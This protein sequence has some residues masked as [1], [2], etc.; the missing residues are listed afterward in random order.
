MKKITLLIAFI[1]TAVMVNAQ[2]INFEK[3]TF[4]DAVSKAKAENKLVFIDFYTTWCGP[5]KAMD[6]NIFP[7]EKVGAYFNEKFVSIK[8]DAEKGEGITLAKKY[9]VKGYPTLLFLNNDETEKRPF[10]WCSTK[11]G[12]LCELC[13]NCFG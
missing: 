4:A 5:C 10:G 7:N 8:L 2:G 6:A 11:S 3:S 1:L 9:E 12:I 13:K